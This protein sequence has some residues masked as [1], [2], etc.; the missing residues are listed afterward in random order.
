MSA[1][2]VWVGSGVREVEAH[3]VEEVG[4]LLEASRS[5]PRLCARPVRIVVPSRSLRL[6]VCGALLR[7]LGPALAGVSVET[8]EGLAR[9][10]LE[11]DGV[12]LPA[13][14]L[15]PVAVRRIARTETVLARDL[16]DLED[17]YGGVAAG[18]DDL[19]DAGFDPALAEVLDE[20]LVLHPVAG[21]HVD[22][23]RALARV[24]VKLCGDRDE[25]L[26]GHRS[27]LFAA[28]RELL[29]RDPERALPLRALF[30]QGFADAT[31]VQTD[32]VAALVRQCD[33][34]VLLDRPPDPFSGAGLSAGAVFG[35]RFRERLEGAAL[36]V[37]SEAPASVPS[38]RCCVLRAPG[39]VAEARA[40]A[41]R[42]R[43]LIDR[44]AQPERLAVVARDLSPYRLPL[45]RQLRR[46]G[47]PFSGLAEAGAAAPAG[48]WLGALLEVLARCESV[49]AERWLDAIARLEETGEDGSQARSELSGALRTDLR[50]SLHQQGAVRLADV[51]SLPQRGAHSEVLTAI[52][53]LAIDERGP[54]AVRR[55]LSGSALSAVARA[56]AATCRRLA[57]WPEV[58]SL[59]DHAH[60]LR[61]LV[62]SDLGWSHGTPGFEE[63]DALLAG[64]SESS[65]TL[66]L[67]RDEWLRVLRR[68]LEGALRDPLGGSGGGVQVLGVM[69]ARARSFDHL[70]LM[71]MN[72]GLFPRAVSED[73]L[74][75][76]ELRRALR[77][78]LPD[79]PVKREGHDEER[80]LF[81]QLLTCA[82]VLT[83]SL[84]VTD[85]DGRPQPASPLLEALHRSAA[86]VET[87]DVPSHLAPWRADSRPTAPLSAAEHALIAGVHATRSAYGQLFPVAVEEAQAELRDEAIA[88][89]ARDLTVARLAVLAEQDAWGG[90]RDTL[91]PYYGYT[92]VP[93]EAADPRRAPLYV[94]ALE[95]TARCPWRA[96]LE[97]TL[98]IEPEVDALAELPGQGS[99]MR[100]LGSVVHA[101][102]ERIA[103]AQLPPDRDVENPLESAPTEVA[104]PAQEVVES[105]ALSCAENALQRAGIPIPGFAR[106]LARRACAHLAVARAVDWPAPGS[107]L[108]V[109]GTELEGRLSTRDAEGRPR[110]IL[111]RADRVDRL[112]S[113][114]RFVDYK[115]GGPPADAKSE[116]KRS[117]AQCGAVARGESL[118]A[119]AYA[120]SEPGA[121][122]RYLYLRPDAAEHAREFEC[123]AEDVA[124]PFAAAVGVLLEARDRGS[125]VPRLRH[126]D[127]DEEPRA[128][129]HCDVKE[130]CLRGDSGAR[131]RLVRFARDHDP[132]TLGLAERALLAVWNLPGEPR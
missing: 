38:P 57:H 86:G 89:D 41:E 130:A 63:V 16:D 111:F 44:G 106:V 116:A 65:A 67:D 54:G 5:E 113:G 77:D 25:V 2:S 36:A 8:L 75:P 22:R 121:R 23:A 56:A 99:L 34:H 13:S 45:R 32:L 110:E 125:F 71:G 11:R 60:R 29:E 18:I 37:S 61:D 39:R 72:R 48:R 35:A 128:C 104:W 43:D 95:A 24:A 46:L 6:H 30:V 1:G 69:E 129:A 85:D 20:R 92:G 49:A 51:A 62:A 28:A 26:A 84:A 88:P 109:V 123:G 12:R 33:A 94:T 97:R 87:Q 126:P 73:P 27:R 108:P 100:L 9:G 91:G 105:T 59:A 131:R 90:A 64:A 124:E 15:I 58:A 98:R 132:T 103:A 47:V 101:S 102:L 80:F 118:Q 7:Q 93:V 119:A 40:V 50:H 31:G 127:L 21:A 74:L 78:V 83:L 114:L 17:G 120:L 76:D 19:L 112:A 55:R 117:E 3:L 82:P 115:T 53:G 81:A 122:G 79:L 52:E 14:R 4:A 96:F 70:F 10:I 42:L 107:T 68:E 66:D